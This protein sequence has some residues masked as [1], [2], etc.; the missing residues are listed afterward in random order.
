MN[1]NVFPSTLSDSEIRVP[2][3][4]SISHRALIFGAIADGVSS[5][6]GFLSSDDCLATLRAFQSMGLVVDHDNTNLKVYGLGLNGLKGSSIPY[7]LGNSGTAVRLLTGLLAAQ[8]FDSVLLGDESLS[9]R[10]MNRV[11][12]PLCLMGAKIKSQNGCLPLKIKGNQNLS[13]INYDM[14]LASAQVKSSIILAALYSNKQTI[15]T[16]CGIT[17][18]H[19]ER[20]LISMSGPIEVKENKVIIDTSKPLKPIEMKIPGDFSS[21]SFLIAAYLIN[22]NKASLILRDIGI[23]P[24]R[25]GFLSIVKLMGA[26][27]ELK[28]IGSFGN[29]PTADIHVQSS[30]LVGI[31]I[32]DP[33]LISLAIDEF[34]I[35]FILAAYAQ[36]V[37]KI[38]GI[39]ELRF[40]ESDRIE[41]M[42]IGMKS[43]GVSIK[44]TDQGVVIESSEFQGGIVD[45]F[46]DHR[47]AMSFVIA[48]IAA[49]KEITVKNIEN[50]DTSFPGFKD[51]MEQ[52]GVNLS[53][54]IIAQ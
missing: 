39:D 43:L 14:P 38:S 51:L 19:S 36:G 49:N 28:N 33:N 44:D 27:I 25:I 29:E 24:T 18:D 52:I 2:G 13:D 41:S 4:K 23:N 1:Y 21:A 8:N 17:R 10:P 20:M 12:L 35:I 40:K 7:D 9:I 37:T 53:L 11:I 47:I 6:T 26:N 15:I 42:V 45:S 3:D 34:P 5:F 50:I 48:A 46:G 30:K 16:E 54:S 31:N 32:Y 22:K